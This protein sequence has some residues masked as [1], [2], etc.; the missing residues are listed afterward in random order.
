MAFSAGKD[1]TVTLAAPGGTLTNFVAS[2]SIS[3]NADM[4]DVTNLGDGDRQFIQGLRNVTAQI[5]GYFDAAATTG[6]DVLISAAFAN[7]SSMTAT[8]VFGT[9]TTRTYSFSSWVSSYETSLTVDGLIAFSLTL[10]GTGAVTV[11]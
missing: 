5:S 4:L 3:R 6:S 1:A 8:I 7:G 11:S 2:V 10:Q 9:G